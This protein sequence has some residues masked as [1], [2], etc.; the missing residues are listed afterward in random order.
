MIDADYQA[1]ENKE[2]T[3]SGEH[4]LIVSVITG[5]IKESF[6]INAGKNDLEQDQIMAMARAW[7]RHSSTAMRY[8]HLVNYDLKG[9]LSK[10]EIL[11][12]ESDNIEQVTTKKRGGYGKLMEKIQSNLNSKKTQ[13]L[14]C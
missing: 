9:A 13:A 10:L 5:A 7:L 1:I 6:G 2:E 14:T 11:W 3:L 4:Q 8:S 12:R